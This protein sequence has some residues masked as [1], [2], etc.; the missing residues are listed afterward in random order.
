MTTK[1]S[2]TARVREVAPTPPKAPKDAHVPTTK[3]RYCAQCKMVMA[4]PV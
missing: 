1:K 2:E 3:G 4:E